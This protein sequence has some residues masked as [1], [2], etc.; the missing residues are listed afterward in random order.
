MI[1]R[2]QGK[3]IESNPPHIMVDVHGVG[4][5]IDVPMST[6]YNL[7]PVGHEVTIL[8]HFVVREDAQ[9]LYGFLTAEERDT[10]RL[11]LKV[12]GIGA[13]TALSILSGMS[14]ADLVNAVALQEAGILTKVPG[15]GKKTAERLL[16]ELKDKL[17]GALAGS[18]AVTVSSTST[19]IINAL[20][21]LG[22][23]DR[24]ARAVV[25]KL[26]VDVSVS[27]GIR[28]ALQQMVK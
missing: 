26:P 24:E 4:Y 16:L 9:L 21:G 8:T 28:M 19:D 14:V 17:T 22:Y 12:S 13:R 23:S 18:S 1:G 6:F 5:E 27:D 11:L 7:P 2:I 20:I 25:K 10:F 3:L 15:I